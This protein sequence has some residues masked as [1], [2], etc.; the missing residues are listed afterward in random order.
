VLALL[1]TTA[2]LAAGGPAAIR[3]EPVARLTQPVTAAAPPTDRRRVFVAERSG[4][5]RVIR[6][7]HLLPRP[8]VDLSGAVEIRSRDIRRDQGGF[9]SL[10]FAPDYATSRRLYVLYTDRAH[11]VR[12]DELRRSR[13]S[14]D[15]ADPASRRLV[16]AIPRTAPVDVAGHLAFGPDRRLFASFG[17]GSSEDFSHDLSR[18]NGKLVR[19]DPRAG[20]GRAYTV[21][22]DNPFVSTA[23]ARPEIWARGLRVAWSFSFDRAGGLALGDVGDA[24]F[25]EV[26]YAPRGT[27]AGADY[28]WPFVEGDHTRRPGG[29]ALTAPV[30][31]R[32]HGPHV[33]AIVGGLVVSDPRL[34][35]LAGRYLYG[36]FCTGELRSAHLRLPRATGD[37]R[38]PATVPGL[39]ALAQDARGRVYAVSI[40]GSVF[41][42]AP[43]R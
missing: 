31:T 11:R 32:A 19:I 38:E 8:F 37:R 1:A 25:E 4:R 42:L 28:G 23:G 18:L 22:A 30:L 24:R 33:C 20:G 16:L 26:D 12:L 27:G 5:I 36:D 21:P 40:L 15:R 13:A 6:D 9:L 41:R 2:A 7:G 17:E 10:V 3:L 34:R 29:A 39:D 35:A 43:A 14:A